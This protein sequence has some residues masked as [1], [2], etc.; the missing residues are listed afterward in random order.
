[1]AE[2]GTGGWGDI[3]GWQ[4]IVST[5]GATMFGWV[6]NTDRRQG[7]LEIAFIAAEKLHAERHEAILGTLS[8]IRQDVRELRAT[9]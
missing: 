1:V 2:Q 4:A 6:W 8:E 7:K 5:V 3:S 9:R